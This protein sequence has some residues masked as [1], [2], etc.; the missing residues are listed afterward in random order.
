MA[1][2]HVATDLRRIGGD[3]RRHAHRARAWLLPRAKNL[4]PVADGGATQRRGRTLSRRRLTVRLEVSAR[5][6]G[7]LDGK[8]LS[9]R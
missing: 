7:R 3:R 1:L 6:L 9:F 4:C 8:M 5:F 2:P